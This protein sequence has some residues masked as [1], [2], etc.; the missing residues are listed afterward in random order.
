MP[1]LGISKCICIYHLNIASKFKLFLLLVFSYLKRSSVHL[2]HDIGIY[3]PQKKVIL[4]PLEMGSNMWQKHELVPLKHP[5]DSVN[6]GQKPTDCFGQTT[7][8]ESRVNLPAKTSMNL[9]GFGRQGDLFALSN[10]NSQHHFNMARGTSSS[11]QCP[12][13]G[14]PRTLMQSQGTL[15]A[16]PA[17]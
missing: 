15:I 17:P 3:P 5:L 1:I 13:G 16:L 2:S 14:E 4:L 9:G 8:N 10:W 7:R 12:P 6:L 11:L